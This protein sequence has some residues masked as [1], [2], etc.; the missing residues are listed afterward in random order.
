MAVILQHSPAYLKWPHRANSELH[1]VITSCR[2]CLSLHGKYLPL[3]PSPEFL[4]Q[5]LRSLSSAESHVGTT[6]AHLRPKFQIS[7]GEKSV[8]LSV[9]I[10][11]LNARSFA[12]C[13]L[14]SI[15]LRL[16]TILHNLFMTASQAYDY[17]RIALLYL[18]VLMI[19]TSAVGGVSTESLYMP[20]NS[21]LWKC[22]DSCH[23]SLRRL[24]S[25]DYH[26]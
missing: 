21:L 6:A 9:V 8:L 13:C 1:E 7:L 4:S 20:C 2:W 22:L 15:W 12:S 16:I 10:K 17:Y 19:R 11:A 5:L 25:S 14:D 18:N 26:C 23:T 24:G 3:S